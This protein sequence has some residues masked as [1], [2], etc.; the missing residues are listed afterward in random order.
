MKLSFNLT[1]EEAQAF[2]NF[3][4]SVNVNGNSEEDFIKTAFILGLRSME[5]T[6]LEKMKEELQKQSADT[7]GAVE[8]VEDDTEEDATTEETEE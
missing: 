1:K 4:S 6:I 7:S 3:F 8:F 2:K 5:A